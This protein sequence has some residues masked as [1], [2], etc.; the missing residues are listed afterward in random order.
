MTDTLKRPTDAELV[1]LLRRAAMTNDALVDIAKVLDT[2]ASASAAEAIELRAAADALAAQPV[3]TF[4]A[5]VERAAV[6]IDRADTE[7]RQSVLPQTATAADHWRYLATA[8]L[9]AAGV[10]D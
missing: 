3:D 10:E 8:A 2:G 6:A 1:N 4:D 7:R 5:R 9:R